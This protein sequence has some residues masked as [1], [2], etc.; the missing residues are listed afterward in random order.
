[1]HDQKR[2]HA[3]LLLGLCGHGWRCRCDFTFLTN[4]WAQCANRTDYLLT[5]GSTKQSAYGGGRPHTRNQMSTSG[6]K[7]G[8]KLGWGG[9]G[10]HFPTP[11]PRGVSSQIGP[12]T[13][14][15]G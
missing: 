3:G 6:Q 12:L 4:G 13:M 11:P 1:M 15:G 14:P 8:R 9:G 10:A 2:A 7:V 5:Y